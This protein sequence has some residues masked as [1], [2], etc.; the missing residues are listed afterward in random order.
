MPE[1]D[2]QV[3][4]EPHAFPAE[5]Q[6]HEVGRSHQGQHRE[7]EQRQ[8]GEEPGLAAIFGH[9][10]PRVD[11][12]E[13]RDGVDHH[14]HDHRQGVD[15]D[16]PVGGKLADG[17]EWRQPLGKG[18]QR[19]GL[20]LEKHVPGQHHRDE[21]QASSDAHRR[22]IADTTAD[23]PG[24]DRADQRTK[25]DNRDEGAHPFITEASST[26]I[27]PRLRKKVTRIARPTAASAAATVST[28]MA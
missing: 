14:Q 24:D 27:S 12:D 9:V 17:D 10:A 20:P 3:T 2:Q 1:A 26:A 15:A 5:E 18:L 28:N 6:L 19:A 21:Q 7:G 25:N 23:Q 8:I 16:R 13:R 22:D 11:V 4:C